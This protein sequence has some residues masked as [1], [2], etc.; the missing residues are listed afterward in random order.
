M[1]MWP[2]TITPLAHTEAQAEAEPQ[3]APPPPP[4]PH[5]KRAPRGPP[6]PPPPAALSASYLSPPLA[7][8]CGM[9]RLYSTCI[10]PVSHHILRIPLYPRIIYLHLASLQ[11]IHG[12]PL[13]LTVSSCIRTY[14]AVSSC[15][16]LYL[17]SHRIPPP[18]KWDMTKSTL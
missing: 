13:Y 17:V 14:L 2:H 15:I 18:R 12:S 11:Q 9:S 3:A 8:I 5:P 16:Q 10:P 4:P 7:C 1:S 6:P